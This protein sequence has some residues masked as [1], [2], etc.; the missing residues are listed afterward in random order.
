MYTYVSFTFSYS[1]GID[2]VMKVMALDSDKKKEL[3]NVGAKVFKIFL[4][5]ID[6]DMMIPT[7]DPKPESPKPFRVPPFVG[8]SPPMD[9]HLDILDLKP[10]KPRGRRSLGDQELVYFLFTV[11]YRLCR[12]LVNYYWFIFGILQKISF[13][14]VRLSPIVAKRF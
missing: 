6:T 5:T 7:T 9:R 12:W 11:L 13:V 3:F 4:R 2:I 8:Q 14:G 1:V 10:S